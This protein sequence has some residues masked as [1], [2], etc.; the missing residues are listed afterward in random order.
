M[1]ACGLLG[2]ARY[3]LV[4]KTYDEAPIA[5]MGPRQQASVFVVERE[6]KANQ[7][8]RNKQT[9]EKLTMLVSEE[10]NGG[11]LQLYRVHLPP[12]RPSPP[13]HFHLAFSET[14]AVQE[15][16]LA[17]YLGGERR[18]VVLG[19]GES[20]TAQ[21]GQPHTFANQTDLP[22]IMTVETKPPG[23]VVRAFQLAYAVAND[24][25]AAKDGCPGIH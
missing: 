18:H 22:R 21:L 13:L 3:L 17:M 20:L 10:E 12:H 25:G 9:G 16:H 15:G 14:F 11:A 24:G 6:V 5:F 4:E 1:A 7:T 8:I 2:F 23:G 19:P